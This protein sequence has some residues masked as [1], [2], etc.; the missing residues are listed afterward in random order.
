MLTL[1]QVKL[2]S[3][4]R[5][6]GLHPV[7]KAAMEA[8]IERSYARGVNIVIT[9]GLRTIE[10]QNAL[11]AHVVQNP[12]LLSLTQRAAPVTTTLDLLLTLRCCCQMGNRC[13]GI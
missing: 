4:K 1:D 11:Y 12:G 2:K 10:E 9:Q 8:L 6:I 5:L 7:L 3:H 13:L